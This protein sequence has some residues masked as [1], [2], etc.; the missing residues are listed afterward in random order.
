[1]EK[2]EKKSKKKIFL[3]IIIILFIIIVF[4]F[5]FKNN[6]EAS[7][8]GIYVKYIENPQYCEQDSDC[9]Q[10]SNCV[11]VNIYNFDITLENCKSIADGSKCINNKCE[12]VPHKG[13]KTE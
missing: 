1:M 12:L 2:K 8:K 10:K 7:Y 3:A 13:G 4:L 9:D 6:I 5:V 11:P